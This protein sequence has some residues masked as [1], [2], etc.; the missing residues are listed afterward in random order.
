[1]T[2]IK[3]RDLDDDVL[4]KIR[5]RARENGRSMEM[6][7]RLIIADAVGTGVTSALW[8]SAGFDEVAEVH[9]GRAYEVWADSTCYRISITRKIVGGSSLEWNSSIDQIYVRDVFG[10]E[11]DAQRIWIRPIGIPQRL[12]GSSA[13]L[14]LR[15]AIRWLSEWAGV[16]EAGRERRAAESASRMHPDLAR[17]VSWVDGMIGEDAGVEERWKDE[18]RARWSISTRDFFVARFSD[19]ELVLSVY[20]RGE[21]TP[22]FRPETFPFTQS[23]AEDAANLIRATALNL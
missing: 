7:L 3:I 20:P 22:S 19:A 14:A 2:D 5:E 9:P 16:D 21:I 6:E 8:R 1:M 15:D 23:G 17:V 18:H 12:L 4:E 13:E 10:N 11:A